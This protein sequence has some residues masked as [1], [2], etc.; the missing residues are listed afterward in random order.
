MVYTTYLWEWFIPP[1]YGNGLYHLFMGTVYTS[2]MW[3]KQWESIPKFSMF[4]G[5]INLPFPFLG[6]KHNIGA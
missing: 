5:G 6:G 4:I 3:L 2:L 1:I